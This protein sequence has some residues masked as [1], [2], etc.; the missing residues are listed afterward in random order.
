MRL[1]PKRLGAV[2]FLVVAIGF[3][4]HR[5]RGE[6]G[7]ENPPAEAGAVAEAR[8]PAS[9]EI[10]GSAATGSLSAAVPLSG[11]APERNPF[12]RPARPVAGGETLPPL[13]VLGGIRGGEAP[14]AWLDGQA[15]RAGEVVGRWQVQAIEGGRV[16]LVAPGGAVRILEAR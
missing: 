12:R 16:A 15:A 9:G 11:G 6:L 4:G 1:D 10:D 7:G 13:P 5:L 3:L 8:Q 2:L 14:V